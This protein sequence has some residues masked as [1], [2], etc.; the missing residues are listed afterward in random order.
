MPEYKTVAPQ[1]EHLAPNDLYIRE[2]GQGVTIPL[3]QNALGGLGAALVVGIIGWQVGMQTVDFLTLGAV[4][5]GLLFGVACVVRAFRDE[6]RFVVGAYGER[7][8]KATRA[9]LEAEVHQLRDE[10]KAAHSQGVMSGKHV[11]LMATERLLGDYYERHLDVTRAAA[12]QRGYTR[13]QWD[14]AQKLLRAAGVV[15]GH[16]TLKAPTYAEAWAAVLRSQSAGMGSYVVTETG[17]MV[18]TK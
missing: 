17:D 1:P 4:V 3:A 5:G 13:R 2:F 16:G 12:T 15:D 8:D 7:Q 11:A 6:V 18:R 10:L 14:D 9:A